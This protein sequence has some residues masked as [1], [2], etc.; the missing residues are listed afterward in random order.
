MKLFKGISILIVSIAMLGCEKVI[1]VDLDTAAPALVVDASIDWAKHTIGNKQRIKLS[2]TTGYYSAEFPT[3]S[4]ATIYITNSTNT[5]FNFSEEA[6]AGEYVCSNFEPVVGETYTLTITLHGETYKAVETLTGAPDIEELSQNS[7]GGMGGD[8][9]EIQ[10]SFQDDGSAENYYMA[11]IISN[12]VAF[13]EYFLESDEMFQG[14][15]M[16]RYYS[17]EKDLKAGDVINVKLYGVSRRF[18][19][20]FKKIMAASGEGTGPFPTSPTPVSGNIINQS[21][22]GNDALGYFRLSEVAARDYTI[23]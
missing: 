6:V 22:T 7:A 14:K 8:E 4:E 11:G 18:F 17:H 15:K 1:K 16:T 13:P 2:T 20:Y 3:V 12:R 10:F 5:V 21:N 9:M 23:Q 19:D